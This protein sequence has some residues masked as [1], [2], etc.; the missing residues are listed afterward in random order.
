MFSNFLKVPLAISYLLVSI[1][2]L[3][4]FTL[5]FVFLDRNYILNSLN[6]ES[7][8]SNLTQILK[9]EGKK[10]VVD[11][12]VKSE[13]NTAASQ[14]R[15]EV[16][17]SVEPFMSFVTVDNVKDFF[18]TN[19]INLIFYLR[20][21]SETWYF[22]LPLSKWGV[23]K[24]FKNSIPEYLSSTNINV[25]GILEFQNKD[26]PQINLIDNMRYSYRNLL[27]LTLISI[28]TLIVILIFYSLLSR[29]KVRES[30]GSLLT[31]TG[32]FFILLAWVSRSASSL[33]LSTLV[34]GD[35]F[36]S[37]SSIFVPILINP[38]SIIF[39]VYG[40]LSFII[41]IILFNSK[42]KTLK[43]GWQN[44]NELVSK[45]KLR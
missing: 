8:Y 28:L 31:I 42:K 44:K 40:M 19:I 6:K 36:T 37:L 45:A 39:A 43:K 41:G 27:I 16:E 13:G 2:F 22:Y 32:I 9:V 26:L 7:T 11:Q 18:D 21:D 12:I 5:G 17:K 25:K 29:N 3:I 24:Q 38:I 4:S 35:L 20:G 15:K 23:L 10:Y 34:S 1:I 33:I 14:M 30:V